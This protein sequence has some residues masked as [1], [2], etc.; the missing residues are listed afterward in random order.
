MGNPLGGGMMKK[1]QEMQASMSRVQEELKELRVEGT[2]AGGLV[3]AFVNGHKEL[4]D[5][6]IAPEAVEEGDVEM[7]EDLIVAAVTS[8]A[9]A[10]GEE[11]QEKMSE[12]SG[13]LL[14]PGMDLS[15]LLGQG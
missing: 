13:G 11:A 5:I 4:V 3:T 1:I 7:L 9:G 6:K 15:N 10:A 8:A 12:L 14:P 2:A